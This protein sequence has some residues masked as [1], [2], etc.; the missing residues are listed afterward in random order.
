[1]DARYTESYSP[2]VT[3][4]L[5]VAFFAGALFTSAGLLFWVQPLIAKMLLPL[6]GGAPSVWNTCMVFFQALLLAGYAYVLAIGRFRI[7]TQILIHLPLL[8]VAGAVLPFSISE[9]L[10]TQLPSQTNPTLWLLKVLA[11]TVGFPFFVLSA[12]APLLQRWF[13]H[14]SHSSAKDPY[15]LYAVSNAGSMLSL[16]AFP[17]VLEPRWNL[18]TQSRYWA[19]GYVLLALLIGSCAILIGGKQSAESGTVAPTNVERVPL[20]KRMEWVALALIPSS[21]ML[22]VT[23]HISTDV[24]SMPLIWIIPLA[25]YLLTF[26]LAFAN[27]QVLPLKIAT[28]LTPVAVVGLGFIIFLKPLISVWNVIGLHLVVFFLIAF[29]CHRRLALARPSVNNLANYYLCISIGGVLG[30]IFNALVAPFV[31]S[32]P[33]EYPLIIIAACPVLC[34]GTAWSRSWL[35]FAFPVLVAVLMLGSYLDTRE[36]SLTTQRNFFGVWRVSSDEK[37][38]FHR[39]KHGSTTHGWQFTDAEKRCKPTT[40]FHNDGP[41]GQVFKAFDANPSSNKVGVIG[42]GAGTLS[43]YSH[44]RQQWDFY[45]IDPAIV[46]IAQDKRYFTYLSDCA[47]A[48][49][50]MILGDARLKMKEAPQA[51]YGL[52]VIDAFSSDSIPSHLVTVEAL[53]LYLSKLAPDGLLAMNISNRYLNLEPLLS[54]LAQEKGMSARI[55]R[56]QQFDSATAKFASSWVVMARQESTLGSILADSRWRPLQGRVV[57]TD[58]FSNILD[59]MK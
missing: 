59:L 42:L 18:G 8:I 7:K 27:R 44:P 40:Y 32:T 39:L 36:R 10:L 37:N 55:R 53:D 51:H 25:L 43:S 22:G 28:L 41:V 9:S 48:S 12:T 57:W 58:D 4:K 11:I 13:S 46:G 1:M 35:K 49:T 38:E 21:L 17:F 6:L 14:S 30:G 54:G 33:F 31:F 26:I 50:R 23:T 47:K 52:F 19:I 45:E 15:F 16:L 3:L 20:I 56:D 34:C 29:I 2:S 5:T 24:A